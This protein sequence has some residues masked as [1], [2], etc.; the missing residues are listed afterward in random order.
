[1]LTALSLLEGDYI[2][3]KD[4][5]PGDGDRCIVRFPDGSK[6]DVVL[7]LPV[8][9]DV[10][11]VFYTDLVIPEGV[12]DFATK[13]GATMDL[14]LECEYTVFDR[15]VKNQTLSREEFIR[16]MVALGKKL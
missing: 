5:F 10:S 6:L 7:K 4:S 12:A 9:G 2:S 11:L 15:A 13:Q 16:E 14:L 1:M 3:F 8:R